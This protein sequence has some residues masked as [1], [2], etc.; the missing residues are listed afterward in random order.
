MNLP[1]VL[2]AGVALLLIAAGSLAAW[3]RATYHTW[4]G[5]MPTAV[6]W[7]GRDYESQETYTRA[8]MTGAEAPRKVRVVGSYPLPFVGRPL[9][10]AP[11]AGPVKPGE[12]C[13]MG[14]YV[15]IGPGRYQGYS[16][17]GGP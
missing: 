16:L 1:N 9:L 7:C 15:Q 4:P 3:Y 2:P 11:I 10:A 5:M 17:E 8:Q 13:A 6:H 12:P 14:V